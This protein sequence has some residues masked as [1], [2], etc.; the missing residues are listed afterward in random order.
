MIRYEIN[1]Q[2]GIIVARFYGV[3]MKSQD[4]ISVSLQAMVNNLFKEC[5]FLHFNW[6]AHIKIIDDEVS[7]CGE[8]IG[9]AKC[10]PDDKFDIEVGKGIAKGKLLTKWERLKFRVLDRIYNTLHSEGEIL[11]DKVSRK[12]GA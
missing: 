4:C 2:K 9:K 5:R 1:E 12:M 3:H 6:Q 7:R 10:H 11:F 8:I